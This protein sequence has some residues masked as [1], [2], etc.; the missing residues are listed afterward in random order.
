MVY[1]TGSIRNWQ[2]MSVKIH[3]HCKSLC[4]M[5]TMPLMMACT[6]CQQVSIMHYCVEFVDHIIQLEKTMRILDQ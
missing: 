5:Q 4:Q 1:T 3:V 2:Y 6:K